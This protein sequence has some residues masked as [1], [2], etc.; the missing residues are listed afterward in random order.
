MTEKVMSKTEK[1]EII[2]MDKECINGNVLPNI[3]GQ[4][5]AERA[6]AEAI[7]SQAT[8]GGAGPL[9]YGSAI[10]GGGVG[11]IVGGL[12]G[13]GTHGGSGTGAA[14]GTGVGVGVGVGVAGAIVAGKKITESGRTNVTPDLELVRR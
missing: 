1:K 8:G 14:I 3:D 11:A 6:E 10:V 12:A 5:L 4:V 7:L 13:N 9:I 2:S